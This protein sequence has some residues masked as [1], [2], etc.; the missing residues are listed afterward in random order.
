MTCLHSRASRARRG[1]VIPLIAVLLPA[2]FGM[3]AIVIELGMAMDSRRKAQVAADLAAL[4]GATDIFTN[5]NS[6][7]RNG[8]FFNQ[9]QQA[10]L[11]NALANGF[12][13]DRQS[14]TVTVN[15]YDETRNPYPN[16]QGGQWQTIRP[17]R[18]FIYIEVII[19]AKQPRFFSSIWS[20][21]PLPIAARAVARTNFAAN[22]AGV[23]VLDP[24]SKGSFNVTGGASVVI[25]GDASLVVDSANA[26]GATTTGSGNVLSSVYYF[27]GTPGWNSTS[28]GTF[29]NLATGLFD[30]SIINSGVP[31]TP[32]PLAGL[33]VPTMPPT[34]T[35]PDGKL[36]NRAVNWTGNNQYGAV[37]G[38]LTLSPGTYAG[39]SGSGSGTI[40]LQPGI[41]YM[42]GGGFGI[43]GGASMTVSGPASPDTGNGVMIYNNPQSNSDN[44]S[45]T[46]TSGF[47]YLPAPDIGTYKGISLFQARSA[48]NTVSVNGNGNTQITGTFYAAGGTLGISGNGGSVN[49]I[50]TDK[51][52][53]QYISYNLVVN[54]NGGFVIDWAGGNPVNVRTIQLVE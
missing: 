39:I 6:Y 20:T 25:T 11:N 30:S 9:A 13:N 7:K 44:L 43:S 32:D 51:I 5:Y 22:Q 49:G 12:N 42:N 34:A 3:M 33:P 15:I 53:A 28:S 37:N 41:Y 4:A 23:L 48:T 40:V 36:A 47:V 45:F 2:L 21:D 54:G 27:S 14:N 8:Y 29:N 24:S 17:P 19:N 18:D 31:P 26:A 35:L 1:S 46:G 10:A 38:V 52:G 50:P 16:L